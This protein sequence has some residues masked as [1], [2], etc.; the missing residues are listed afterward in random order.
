MW[1]L[2]PDEGQEG[3][4]P[5]FTEGQPRGFPMLGGTEPGGES[6]TLA[7]DSKA[8]ISLS[9]ANPELLLQVTQPT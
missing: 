6:Q 5:L 1:H 3:A 7:S 9:S 4:M 8:L 2:E